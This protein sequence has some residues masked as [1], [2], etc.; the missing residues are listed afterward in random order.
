MIILKKFTYRS[1]MKGGPDQ[2]CDSW[3][4][5]CKAE[6]L[7]IKAVL[8][9]TGGKDVYVS[10]DGTHKLLCNEWVLLNMISETL[11]DSAGGKAA[12]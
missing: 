6:L 4:F 7:N 1:T 2:E 10:L 12:L 9:C 3:V 8:D 5:S 11:I